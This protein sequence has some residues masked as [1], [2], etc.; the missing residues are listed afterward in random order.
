MRPVIS[1]HLR[2]DRWQPF[3]TGN[4]VALAAMTWAVMFGLLHVAWAA[5]S[6]LLI[7]DSA[8]ASVAFERAWFQVYN[9]VVVLGSFAAAGIARASVHRVLGAHQWVRRLLW[10]VAGV[11][12]IRGAIG[13]SQLGYAMLTRTADRPVL[14]WSIDLAMLVGGTLFAAAARR[15]EPH[16]VRERNAPDATDGAARPWDPHPA[17]RDP[18]SRRRERRS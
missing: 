14:A 3:R 5:G 6:R 16:P 18:A 17:R 9:V 12:I 8:A 10:V 2:V 1:H 15:R 13:A 11:L 4:R 7:Y